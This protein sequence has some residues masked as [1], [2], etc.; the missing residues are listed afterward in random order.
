[1]KILRNQLSSYTAGYRYFGEVRIASASV[2]LF[3]Y[4]SDVEP[5]VWFVSFNNTHTPASTR[6][7]QRAASISGTMDRVRISPQ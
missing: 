6:A 4:P 7:W 1:M 2:F 5:M 3:G